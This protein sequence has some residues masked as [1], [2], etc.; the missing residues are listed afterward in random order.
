M[1]TATTLRARF[2]DAVA[3]ADVDV[4]RARGWCV[5]DDFLD[6]RDADAFRDELERLS[7]ARRRDGDDDGTTT[8]ETRERR[9]Y[10]RPNRTKFGATAVFGKPN[11]YECDMRTTRRRWGRRGETR[12]TRRCGR[13]STRPRMGWRR[14]S[15]G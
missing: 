12:R 10:V 9:K 7:D 15:N 2:A 1:A 11:I 4:L 6:S 5:I 8:M 3:R 13:F 14:R